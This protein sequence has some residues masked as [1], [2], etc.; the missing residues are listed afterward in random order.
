MLG[1]WS[2]VQLFVYTYD[3][4]HSVTIASASRLDRHAFLLRWCLPLLRS[5]HF[6]GGSSGTIAHCLVQQ[7]LVRVERWA[8]AI[9]VAPRC[10]ALWF[11]LSLFVRLWKGMFCVPH[12]FVC[13]ATHVEAH[14]H[15]PCGRG[16]C[17]A[18]LWY[19]VVVL[20][21]CMVT[22]VVSPCDQSR[23]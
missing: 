22:V 2:A 19:C 1:L 6:T 8:C 7:F 21:L 13:R 23:V 17:S 14:R 15:A 12:C 3:L 11:L 10:Y 4:W 20:W 18:C 16:Q 9:T 5:L